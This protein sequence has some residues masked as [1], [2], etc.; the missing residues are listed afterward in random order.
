MDR[1]R[2]LDHDELDKF[3]CSLDSLRCAIPDELVRHYLARAGFVSD[4]VRLERLIALSAQKFL[5]DIAQDA[6][7]HSRLRTTSLA[8]HLTSSKKK[9]AS[10]G[11]TLVLTVDDLER[12]LGEYGVQYRKPP[13]FADST[14]AGMPSEAADPAMAPVNTTANAGNSTTAGANANGNSAAAAPAANSTTAT[15]AA[16][17]AGV[18]DTNNA[19]NKV[20]PANAQAPAATS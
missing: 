2:N 15:G 9:A 3:V 10:A 17:P 1:S 12:A 6:L 8:H 19:T 20:K 11:E 5:A 18:A 16:T 7:S 14:S 4:D 13:Y